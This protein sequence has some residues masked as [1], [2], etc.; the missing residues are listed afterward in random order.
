[1]K[2]ITG[3]KGNAN[4]E[5]FSIKADG[6]RNDGSTK[7]S[8]DYT[9]DYEEIENKAELDE[10]FSTSDLI[11]LA[12]ARLKATAN[13]TARQKAVAPYA[14][15]PNSPEVIRKRMLADLIKLGVP[16]ETAKGMVESA[17][18]AIAK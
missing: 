16:E 13:S 6:S 15:D 8:V 10:K 12:N 2:N 18:A 7:V 14:A 1:M 4:V 3:E 9:Y 5:D 17:S 11:K